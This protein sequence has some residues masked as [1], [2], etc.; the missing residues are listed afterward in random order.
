MSCHLRES[1]GNKFLR[2]DVCKITCKVY[3]A[4]L[5]P[6][7]FRMLSRGVESIHT[8]HQLSVTVLLLPLCLLSVLKQYKPSAPLHLLLILSHSLTN[9]NDQVARSFME[10]RDGERL[11]NMKIAKTRNALSCNW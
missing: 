10:K 8:I 11:K 4:A 7:K 3:A 1:G 9:K 5:S 6:A 2:Y